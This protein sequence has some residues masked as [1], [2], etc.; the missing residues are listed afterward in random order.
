MTRRA[1][2]RS[3]LTEM[4]TRQVA[5]LIAKLE[6]LRRVRPKSARAVERL[7]HMLADGLDDRK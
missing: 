4:Q 2:S 5:R 7:I 6:Y 1:R 3:K